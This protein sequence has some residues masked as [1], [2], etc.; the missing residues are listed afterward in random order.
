MPAGYYVTFV[1]HLTAGKCKIK[2]LRVVPQWGAILRKSAEL[3]GPKEL[4][5]GVWPT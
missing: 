3:Y 1:F 5:V 2:A 4:Y